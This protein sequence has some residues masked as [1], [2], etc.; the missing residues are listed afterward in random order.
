[1]AKK[2]GWGQVWKFRG[3]WTVRWWEGGKLRQKSF[4]G[5]KAVA[6]RFLAL[7]Q[8]E[9][10]KREVAGDRPLEPIRFDQLLDRYRE[11]F[12]GEKKE[13]TLIRDEAQ[14][15]T[16]ALPHFR[17]MQMD[18]IRRA[19]VERFLSLRVARRRIGPGTRNRLLSMLSTFFR[20]AN[21]L[22]HARVNPCRG[23]KRTKEELRP[24]PFLDLDDQVRV[25][26]VCPEP[27]RWLVLVL[28]DLGLRLGEAL[29]LEWRDV[30]WK[31]QVVTIRKSKNKKPRT[32]PFTE[33]GAAA[34]REAQKRWRAAGPR[35]PN[36]IFL[37]LSAPT[38]TG[39][40]C[41]RTG[42][43]KRWLKARKAAG[44][45]SLRI[46]DLRHIWASTMMEAGTRP[47]ALMELGGWSSLEMVMRYARHVSENVADIARARMQAYLESAAASKR[48][49]SQQEDSGSSGKGDQRPLDPQSRLGD[50][51]ISS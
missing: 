40:L 12:A 31:R 26:S 22:N 41:L 19:D 10:E 1:M 29:A 50:C 36:R 37:E 6:E 4:T 11:I 2:R 27:L 16:A 51:A 7:Q 32:V 30:D 25:A 18:R 13:S 23:I 45:P 17:R 47:N 39:E 14:L 5:A 33:R 38:K 49:T 43:R 48:R 24:V 8:T 15:R 42:P 28:L 21:A 44:F 20:K 9:V 34:L 35:V 46:H 3:K